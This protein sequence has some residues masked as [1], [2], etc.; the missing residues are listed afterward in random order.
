MKRSLSILLVCA[1]GCSVA[2][3]E[4]AA[5]RGITGRE[6]MLLRF[7]LQKDFGNEVSR[8]S[9]SNEAIPEFVR[10]LS[11]AGALAGLSNLEDPDK[12]RVIVLSLGV[13]RWEDY[14][15]AKARG[16]LK[17]ALQSERD[18]WITFEMARVL[19][20]LGDDAGK[21]VLIKALLGESGYGTSSG[22]EIGKA[23]IPLLLLDYDFPKGFPESLPNY[24]W[25]G[26]DEYLK[27]VRHS[28]P[29]QSIQATP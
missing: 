19:A 1:V 16:A 11:F 6:K 7:I 21:E 26:L 20:T 22:I 25:G 23:T 10:S 3:S 17:K 2:R 15:L 27:E 9:V 5:P 18:R 28:R 14:D 29:N 8:I 4:T 12:R 24:A 13:R